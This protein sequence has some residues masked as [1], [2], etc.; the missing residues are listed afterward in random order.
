MAATKLSLFQDALRLIAD[1][2]LAT[3]TDD[4]ESQYALSDAWDEAVSFCLRQAPWR[5]A[6]NTA[7]LVAGGSPVAGYAY[8][9]ARP[10]DWLRT[11]T[12]AIIGPDGREHPVDLREQGVTI[13]A[14]VAALSM[15]YVGIG[16]ANPE[17][18]DNPWP[19]HFAQA[20]AAYLAFLV[21]ERVTG[22][23][24]ATTRFSQL[25]NQLLGEAVRIDAVPEDRWLPYQRTGDML[26][27][28]R[29]LLQQG[30]WRFA[31]TDAAI[32]V[33]S[34]LPARGFTYSFT[35]PTDW[36]RTYRIFVST[37]DGQERPIDVREQ[38]GVWST[39]R[40][41]FSVRYVSTVRGLDSSLWGDPFRA[42]LLAYLDA[43]RP[44]MPDPQQKQ[45]QVP[46][47]Y[48]AL[49]LAREGSADPPDPMLRHQFSGAMQHEA[50]RL[51]RAGF[52]RF[53]MTTTTAT[54]GGTP[55]AGYTHSFAIPADC[56]RTHKLFLGTVGRE[57]PFDVREQ[58]GYWHTNV[59][60]FTAGYVSTTRGLDPAL[61]PEPFLAALASMLDNAAMPAGDGQKQAAAPAADTLAMALAVEADPPHRWLRF[62]LDGHFEASK[63]V[64]LGQG[65]WAY[66][67]TAGVMRGLKEVQLSA[68]ADQLSTTPSYPFPYRLPLPSDWMHTHALFVPWDGQEC[69]IN[70]SESGHDWSTDAETFV[71]RYVS[72][73]VLDSSGWP[74]EIADA[75]HAHCMWKTAPPDQATLRAQEYLVKRDAAR[76]AYSRDEDEFLRFQL[77]GKFDQARKQLLEQGRWRFAIRTV[78][79]TESSDA[80]PAELSDGALIDGYGYR[81]IR[82]NDLL[83]TV[84]VHYLQA[85]APYS[86]R[87]D[88]DF[89]DEGGCFFA[90][91]TPITVRYVSRMG[92]DST[93][94][95][96]NFKDAVLL[97]C[98][99]QEALADPKMVAQAAALLQMFEARCREVE[100]LDDGRDRPA[101]R[102]SRFVAARGGRSDYDRQMGRY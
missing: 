63:A 24:A 3:I 25:F 94:W 27:G 61:W 5:F 77:S 51:L 47:W 75:V 40:A 43:G 99:Y 76:K 7:S 20:V 22:E 2:R 12:I 95:P 23:R 74:D 67:D 57:M 83:R 66:R 31:M 59:A 86:D 87:R 72:T 19:E 93:K 34:G 52:W 44:E 85:A 28:A 36:L 35:Q 38:A 64:V 21:V 9:F 54:A 4:V 90:N 55:V 60:A 39:N 30:F 79:L 58:G 42:A 45:E 62:Q 49:L 37:A 46:A 71:A 69:P 91:F 41:S 29:T 50:H 81:F 15:R 8:S 14:N 10:S 98:K 48:Q 18:A 100:R 16:Y 101:I 70:I 96:L 92:L 26:T 33:Q 78:E 89:R 65:Y 6:L 82:P 32:S 88:I 53:A 80:I 1:A 73:E 11:H 56:V 97:W 17:L 13:S 68:L 102:R 84:W